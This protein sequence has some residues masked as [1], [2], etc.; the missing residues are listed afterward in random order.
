MPRITRPATH[1]GDDGTTSTVQGKRVSKDEEEICAYGALDELNSSIGLT[2]SSKLLAPE[3]AAALRIV[4]NDLFHLGSEL[5]YDAQVGGEVTHPQIESRH[6]AHLDDII[7]QLDERLGPLMNFTLPGG[8]PS[9]ASLH[10]SRSVCRRAERQV[11]ALARVK[12]VS[13]L[14]LK[15]LNRLS[16][17]LFLM[18]RSENMAQGGTELVWDSHR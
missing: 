9:A 1:T 14:A 3:A 6:V 18:A 2:L 11:V 8:V 7:A 10:V 12:K 5:G 4:Q 16:D 13:P 17:V 15:Y